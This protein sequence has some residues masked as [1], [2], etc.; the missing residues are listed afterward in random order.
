[1]VSKLKKYILVSFLLLLGLSFVL[2]MNGSIHH[3][4]GQLAS[5]VEQINL[6]VGKVHK[7]GEVSKVTFTFAE[8]DVALVIAPPYANISDIGKDVLSPELLSKMKSFVNAQE[9][10][11]IFYIRQGDLREHRL[12]S[13]LAEPIL[14]IGT[15]K[16]I[17]FL[18]SPKIT[19]GRPVRIEMISE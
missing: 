14:G 3:Q 9:T 2:F 7:T 19:S 16:E 4:T 12:L 8:G 13:Y 10:G 11:H 15:E 17:V 6:Q 5:L 18:I 1:M